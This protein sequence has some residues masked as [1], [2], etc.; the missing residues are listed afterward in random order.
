MNEKKN[1]KIR[2]LGIVLSFIF[3]TFSAEALVKLNPSLVTE[4]LVQKSSLAR[5]LSLN[6]DLARIAYIRQ[7]QLFDWNF[8]A[9]TSHEESRFRPFNGLPFNTGQDLTQTTFGLQKNLLTGTTVTFN[10]AKTLTEF[11]LVSNS[12][13]PPSVNVW[14]STI[15]FSQSLWRN[16]FGQAWKSELEAQEI[17]YKATQL[18]KF[19]DLENLILQGIQRYWA[20]VVSQATYK[21]A[22]ETR[23]RYKTLLANVKRRQSVGFANPGELSLVQ[24]ELEA[25]EQG[26]YRSQMVYEELKDSFLTFLSWEADSSVKKEIVFEFESQLDKIPASLVPRSLDSLR[27]I[28]IAS[29][30]LK[31][32]D[33]LKQAAYANQGPEISLVGQ[34]GVA[35]VHR[36]SEPAFQEWF[37]AERPRAFIG[38]RLQWDFGS[39]W[40]GEDFKNRSLGYE[41][42]N[43]RWTRL[44]REF[45]D[46]Q[47][48]LQRKVLSHLDMTKSLLRQKQFRKKAVEELSQS[49]QLGRI[50]IR[51]LIDTINSAFAN[52]IEYLRSLGEY[53]T[54]LAEWQAFHDQLIPSP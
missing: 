14:T 3:L 24:A 5:E 10:F 47:E 19:E 16:Y 31:A 34:Y 7:L 53:Q 41:Q 36:H 40:R 45:Q 9:E 11:E 21:E 32:A 44:L 39:D 13:L 28:Q 33:L 37:Q 30:R 35:G 17:S 2:S 6:S 42:E 43:L 29:T 22:M 4:H 51:T 23:N 18:Q 8:T 1:R 20:L 38:L 52:E 12:I 49:Y 15:G 54:S 26:I 50:E 27:P 48:N 25:R 46:Q